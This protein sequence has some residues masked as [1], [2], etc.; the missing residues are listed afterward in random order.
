[1]SSAHA[2]EIT[3]LSKIYGRTIALRAVTLRLAAGQ[4]LALLGA[5]GSGKT[6][7][8]K[9]VAGAMSP[10]TGTVALFGRDI[11]R[12]SHLVR[13]QIG[14]LASESYLYDDLTARENL[15]F[16]LTMAGRAA[17]D[18]QILQALEAVRLHSHAGDRVRSF[19]SGMKRRLAIAR[20]QMLQ[21][22]ILLLDEP[23]NSLD[24]DGADLVDGWIRHVTASGGAVVVATHD[25]ERIMTVTHQVARLERGVLEYAGPVQGYRETHALQVG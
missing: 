22:R 1:M 19:S 11:R 13:S 9:I 10:T 7:L 2:L 21:P 18:A 6:T 8:L 16:T 20:V 24:A 23:Y 5:N 15:G 3:G 25:S 17:S 14:L 4:S 12:E